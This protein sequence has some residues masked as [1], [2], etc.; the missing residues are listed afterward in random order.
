VNVLVNRNTSSASVSVAQQRSST[1]LGKFLADNTQTGT[2]V[3]GSA[4]SAGNIDIH[5]GRDT[6]VTDSTL[7]ADND[8]TVNAVRNLT[9]QSAETSSS[10]DTDSTRHTTGNAGTVWKPAVGTAQSSGTGKES[11]TTQ[12]GSRIASPN[13]NV[14]L[15]AGGI[16]TKRVNRMPSGVD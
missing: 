9:I 8:I 3:V 1:G 2:Q 7:V 5:S 15:T 14:K 12:V 11:D 16:Y 13:G 6:T 10:T 4:Q